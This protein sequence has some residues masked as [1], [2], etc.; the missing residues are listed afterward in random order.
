MLSR[1]FVEIPAKASLIEGSIAVFLQ[2]DLSIPTDPK[3]LALFAHGSGSRRQRPRNKYVAKA[4]NED[5]LATLLVDLPTK[6]EERADIRAQKVRCKIRGLVFKFNIKLLAKCLSSISSWL[7]QNAS[8]KDLKLRYFGAST[9]TTAALIAATEEPTGHL[10][11]FYN[12]KMSF[13]TH[14]IRS[15]RCTAPYLTDGR[16]E[17]VII[18]INQ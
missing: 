12:P 16:Q 10:S 3:G 9:G 6:E 5:A 2:G 14:W 11:I 18:A 4:L 17:Y 7:L 15:V 1:S 8:C 13:G